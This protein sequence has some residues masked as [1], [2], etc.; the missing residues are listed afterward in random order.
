[1][2]MHQVK[3]SLL[4]V[5]QL[6]TQSL[7]KEI[8]LCIWRAIASIP[9]FK[10]K[11]NSTPP[12][13]INSK[14]EIKST[15]QG[16]LAA[17]VHTTKNFFQVDD[18][19]PS[20][21][22]LTFENTLLLFEEIF[23]KF[24]V[25][26]TIKIET[27]EGETQL[28]SSNNA[29]TLFSCTILVYKN[30]YIKTEEIVS[31][32]AIQSM[33]TQAK[34]VS[35]YTIEKADIP[36]IN[37]Q[38]IVTPQT[39]VDDDIVTALLQE[40]DN[41]NTT[42]QPTS[43]SLDS[44]Y[45]V[46]QNDDFLT[47]LA[48]LND[49]L[50]ADPSFIIQ[51]THDENIQNLPESNLKTGSTDLLLSSS[52]SSYRTSPIVFNNNDSSTPLNDPKSSK[53]IS[54]TNSEI[55]TLN[56]QLVN[57]LLSLNQ[58][59]ASSEEKNKSHIIMSHLP[60]DNNICLS[61]ISDIEDKTTPTKKKKKKTTIPEKRKKSVSSTPSTSKNLKKYK[62][63]NDNEIYGYSVKETNVKDFLHDIT[64]YI[65]KE[66]KTNLQL[67]EENIE[68]ALVNSN[69]ILKYL[70]KLDSLCKKIPY[71]INKETNEVEIACAMCPLHCISDHDLKFP[72]GRPSKKK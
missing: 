65:K 5:Q 12:Q 21:V 52:A 63:D 1:M 68:D 34:T 11:L 27:G 47:E 28:K 3:T 70:H 45:L 30:G 66:S 44:H 42:I 36:S 24:Y 69:I 23:K 16:V 10:E 9:S 40:S 49:D 64:P 17:I 4:I 43:T 15:I 25:S 7:L 13:N 67:L 18:K 53:N 56:T 32:Y 20:I 58:D 55:E 72:I 26:P 33:D 29:D 22:K 50:I 59:S 35:S 8:T 14:K 60:Y 38:N 61:D 54:T 46:D 48:N 51:P 2:S 71:T 57:S 19:D 37:F 41:K 31:S 62:K 39:V 6:K